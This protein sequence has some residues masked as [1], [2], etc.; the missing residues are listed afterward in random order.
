MKKTYEGLTLKEIKALHPNCKAVYKRFCGLG[1]HGIEIGGK[2]YCDDYP[3]MV[4]H[5]KAKAH[6]FTGTIANIDFSCE[7]FIDGESHGTTSKHRASVYLRMSR[8]GIK[9]DRSYL[10]STRSIRDFMPEANEAAKLKTEINNLVH[11][12]CEDS[13]KAAH[14]YRSQIRSYAYKF[15]IEAAKEK[16]LN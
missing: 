10:S 5:N 8:K 14:D 13:G 15:G 11:M 1:D 9:I 2:F 6:N 12:I 3:M 4:R 16:Y 7:V